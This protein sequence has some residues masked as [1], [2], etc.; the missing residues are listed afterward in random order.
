VYGPP[1]GYRTP[2]GMKALRFASAVAEETALFGQRLAA[3]RKEQLIER[4]NA[5]FAREF[6]KL[7][8]ELQRKQR[9]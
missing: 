5:E 1:D 7:G 2:L 3:T 4:F 8:E 9:Q 6:P